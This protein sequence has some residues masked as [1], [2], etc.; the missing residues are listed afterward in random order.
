MSKKNK[1]KKTWENR[2]RDEQASQKGSLEGPGNQEK[3]LIRLDS[4]DE[5]K[6][7]SRMLQRSSKSTREEGPLHARAAGA[8]QPPGAPGWPLMVDV[9]AGLGSRRGLSSH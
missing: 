3:E 4:A 1:Q 9:Q 6:E 5:S 8:R 7:D 2:E